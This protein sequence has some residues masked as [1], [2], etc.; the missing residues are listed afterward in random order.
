MY[1][2]YKRLDKLKITICLSKFEFRINLLQNM[3]YLNRNDIL[4]GGV[5]VGW[6]FMVVPIRLKNWNMA[7][8]N[9]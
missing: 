7:V 3:Y 9:L 5:V 2:D 6:E 1:F 4:K 8:H